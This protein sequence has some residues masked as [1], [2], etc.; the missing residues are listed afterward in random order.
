MQKRRALSTSDITQEVCLNS[1]VINPIT[2][3]SYISDDLIAIILSYLDTMQIVELQLVNRKLNY[4][5]KRIIAKSLIT[6]VDLTYVLHYSINENLPME[7]LRYICPDLTK[8]RWITLA[9][10]YVPFT[11]PSTNILANLNLI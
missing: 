5:I 11:L 6:K 3:L 7:F 9:A 10:G 1:E 4:I 2:L 8:L